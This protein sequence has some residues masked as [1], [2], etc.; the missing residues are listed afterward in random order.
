[1]A[2][3]WMHARLYGRRLPYAREPCR[4]R[5]HHVVLPHLQYGINFSNGFGAQPGNVIRNAT[6]AAS[7]LQPCG[8]DGGNNLLP[9]DSCVSTA[10]GSFHYPGRLWLR[11]PAGNCGIPIMSY[12]IRAVRTPMQR[13]VRWWSKIC[14]PDGCY[15]FTSPIPLAMVFA[16]TSAPVPI[17]WWI[18][19]AR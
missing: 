16:A 3:R 14:L 18:P 19:A 11:K 15:T 6:N 7:C 8:D 13:T 1:M 12:C 10:A 4:R 17:L 2:R 9:G 5:R